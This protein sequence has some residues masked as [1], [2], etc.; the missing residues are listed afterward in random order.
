MRHV[1]HLITAHQAHLHGR[2]E[3]YNKATLIKD[4]LILIHKFN[5]SV[6][7]ASAMRDEEFGNHVM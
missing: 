1:Y 7:K 6:G 2:F 3:A 4:E 5:T